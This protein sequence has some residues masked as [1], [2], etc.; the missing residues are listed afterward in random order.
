M[1]DVWTTNPEKLREYLRE[2]GSVCGVKGRVLSGRDPAWTCTYDSKGW[3]RDVYIHSFYKLYDQPV[4][5]LPLVIAAGAGILIGLVWGRLFWRP[6][7]PQKHRQ[8]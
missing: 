7:N 3:L 6:R 2:S 5:Y 8:R 4:F 1:P